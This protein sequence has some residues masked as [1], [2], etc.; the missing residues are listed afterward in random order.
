MVGILYTQ[1]NLIGMVILVAIL[2]NQQNI[3]NGTGRQRAFIYLNYSIFVVLFVDTGM[4]LANGTQFPFAIEINW[5]ISSI[6]YI[7][8]AF[9]VFVWYIYISLFLNR[10][11]IRDSKY[12]F[13]MCIPV[14]LNTLLVLIN[15]K[16]NIYFSIDEANIYARSPLFFISILVN[17]PYIMIPFL[18]CIRIYRNS[19]NIIE[20]K[21][22]VLIMKIHVL[23]F[24]GIVAQVLLYGVSL[25]WICTVL[26]LLFIF[27]NFQNKRIST[28]PLTQ[29]NNRYQFDIC[30]QNIRRDMAWEGSYSI[31]FLDVDK[32]K[33][34]NDTY[35]HIVGDGVLI[36]VAEILRRACEKEEAIVGRYGGDE[37]YLFCKSGVRDKIIQSIT[38]LVKAY[39]DA[40]KLGI[41]LSLSIGTSDFGLDHTSALESIIEKA[42]KAMYA[43]KGK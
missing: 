38:Q 42:D 20:K 31:V 33:E 16:H 30:L 1:V 36:S 24:I 7:F 9:T 8:Q 25:I 2:L 22:C 5:A 11:R 6:Y 4:W 34:I 28:D 18:D 21:D 27:I 40:D 10:K 3:D 43:N 41:H 12:F 19:E 17:M 13:V 26:S 39:N 29:L 15:T 14:I 32:F 23:P 35:G 37:F